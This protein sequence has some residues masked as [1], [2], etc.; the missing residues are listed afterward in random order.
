MT[1]PADN[2]NGQTP[3]KRR[4]RA[5]RIGRTTMILVTVFVVVSGVMAMRLIGQTMTAPEWVRDRVEARIERNLPGVSIRFGDIGLVVNEGWRPRVRLRDVELLN[6][7]GQPLL[8]LSD[9]EAS[10]AMR[11]LLKGQVQPKEIA[12]RGAYAEVSRETDGTLSLSFGDQGALVEEATGLPEI[13]AAVD[14][15]L[16]APAL[17][18]LREM[19][20]TSVTLRYEDKRAGRVWTLDGGRAQLTRQGDELRLTSALSLLSG[21]AYAS[22]LELNFTSRLGQSEGEFGVIV[23]DVAAQDIAVQSPA[24]NWLEVLRAPISGALRGSLLADG[25]FGPLN[26]T[27][28]IGKGVLQPTDETRPIPFEGARSYFTFD[29]AT[30]VMVFD[31]LSVQSDWFAGVAEGTAWL[32]GIEAGELSELTAQVT[33]TNATLNPDDLYDTALELPRTTADLRMELDPF[34]VTLGEMTIREQDSLM[35]LRG[36]LDAAPE[37]WQLSLDGGIDT[38]TPAQ[39]LSLWPENA[40]PK[41]RFWVDRNLTGGVLSDV[42]FAMRLEPGSEPNIYVDFDYEDAAIRFMPTMPPIT[43]ATGHASLVDRRLV[44]STTAGKIIAEEGGALDIAGSSFIIPDVGIPRSAPGILRLMADGSVTSVLSLLNRRPIEALEGT[45]LPV[46]VAQGRASASGT[47]A[48]PL[49]DRVMNDEITY[50][51]SGEVLDFA[52]TRLMPEQDLS[53]P[54]LVVVADQ[55]ELQI[56]GA[57]FVQELPVDMRWVQPLGKDAPRGSVI[58]GDIELSQRGLDTF[59]VGLP[60]GS[61]SGVGTAEFAVQLQPDTPPLLSLQSDLD[62]VG[63]RIPALGWSK[64]TGSSGRLDIEGIMSEQPELTRVALS[65]PGL[66]AEGSLTTSPNGGLGQATFSSLRMGD[67]LNARVRLIGR[68]LNAT[69]DIEVRGGTMDLRNSELSGEGDSSGAGGLSVT[70]NRLQITDD[71]ALTD[72]VGNFGTRGGLSG[73]FNGKL[74]GVTAV[75]GNLTP[76]NGRSQIRMTSSNAGGVFRDAGLLQQARGGEF[77]ML[78]QP[79]GP[80]DYNGTLRVTGTRVQEAPAIAA[81]LNAASIIGLLDELSGAGIQFGEVDARFRLSP[82]RLTLYESSAVG[83]SIGLSMDGVYDARSKRLNMQGVVSPVY[84]LNGIGSLLTRKGEGLIGFTYTLTGPAASPAVAVN[85]LSALTPGM[86][87]EVFRAPAPSPVAGTSSGS[88]PT[89]T[90]RRGHNHQDGSA[91]GR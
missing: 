72:F 15:A 44:T 68:G 4:S 57:A 33:I 37:G 77:S 85:P 22:T 87:R 19:E 73:D 18:A 36:T 29:P 70:L 21:R 56:S 90:R 41:P 35:H 64:S 80:T 76:S 23:S 14:S 46:D 82:D 48:L 42:D 13:I 2:A 39:L 9:V 51:L 71:I 78:L 79:D 62:G 20:L 53:A 88:A 1:E 61:V 16:E 50:H 49:K 81:L 27:L 40:A 59:G 63:L 7:D 17:A 5:H 55:D 83:P 3:P 91:G 69:P 45:G 26:A 38:M 47:L 43:G 8:E 32:G 89:P 10:L 25:A 34:R 67:W 84:L 52:S 66:S 54:R 31:E 11:P 24:L 86:L 12:L 74:N 60:P 30:Q 58:D 6:R 75:S 65:A 28:Q